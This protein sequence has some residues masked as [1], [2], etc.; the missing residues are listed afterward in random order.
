M[1]ALCGTAIEANDL[2]EDKIGYLLGSER[3]LFGQV[4]RCRTELQ[5]FDRACFNTFASQARV[6]ESSITTA[7]DRNRLKW[8]CCHEPH[9]RRAVRTRKSPR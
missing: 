1:G 4:S 7:V 6:G 3:F 5:R 9:E 8:L 2:S